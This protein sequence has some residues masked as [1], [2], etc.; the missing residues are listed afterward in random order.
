EAGLHRPEAHV[1]EELADE[2]AFPRH[3]AAPV[4]NEGGGRA[5]GDAF[6]ARERRLDLGGEGIAALRMAEPGRNGPELLAP[7]GNVAPGIEHHQRHAVTLQQ[8]ALDARPV[9]AAEHEVRLADQD[10]L[11]RA[12]VD[13]KVA[14]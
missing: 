13:R 2:R 6:G 4:E 7:P 10:F 9:A 5:P 11:A 3:I 12:A 14:D 1:A 8:L